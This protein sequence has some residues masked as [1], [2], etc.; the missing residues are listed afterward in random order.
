MG[1]IKLKFH[2]FK[3]R[4]LITLVIVE[5]KKSVFIWLFM[6]I[7]KDLRNSCISTEYTKFILHKLKGIHHIHWLKKLSAFEK[8]SKELEWETNKSELF[9]SCNVSVTKYLKKKPALYDLFFHLTKNKVTKCKPTILRF[10]SIKDETIILGSIRK[11][12]SN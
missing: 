8:M 12:N 7:H 10:Y 1:E 5:P 2:Q 6:E 9:E 11:D 4:N 3:I